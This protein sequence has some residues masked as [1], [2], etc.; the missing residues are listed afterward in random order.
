MSYGRIYNVRRLL[1]DCCVVGEGALAFARAA[2]LYSS[3][4]LVHSPLDGARHQPLLQASTG[5]VC[6]NNTV[7]NTKEIQLYKLLVVDFL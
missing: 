2:H 5:P 7:T 4:R 6:I 3:A 1:F